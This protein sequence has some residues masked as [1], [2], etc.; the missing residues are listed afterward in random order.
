[1]FPT[2]HFRDPISALGDLVQ[3]SEGQ[4]NRWLGIG[5]LVSDKGS[6]QAKETFV[7]R[8]CD[9]VPSHLHLHGW[10][11]Q[12]YTSIERLDS[13]DHFGWYRDFMRIRSDFSFLTSDEA[14]SIAVKKTLRQ[15][16]VIERR[17]AR[18][19]LLS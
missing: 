11:A 2:I 12:A 16:R 7:R 1:G 14:I 8:V 5:G 10:G 18:K 13:I 6:R 17:S 3:I 15:N 4:G 19:G 9:S